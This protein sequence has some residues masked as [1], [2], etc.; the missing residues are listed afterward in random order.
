MEAIENSCCKIEKVKELT[1][2]LNVALEFMKE[3][4]KTMKKCGVHC[5]WLLQDWNKNLRQVRSYCPKH[6]HEWRKVLLPSTLS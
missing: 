6:F 3:F 5:G 1:L 2:T 4:D